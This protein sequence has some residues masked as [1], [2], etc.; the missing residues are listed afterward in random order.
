MHAKKR[1]TTQCVE[2]LRFEAVLHRFCHV[3][4]F[5]NYSV[6][7]DHNQEK[8]HPSAFVVLPLQMS[9]IVLHQMVSTIVVVS[10]RQ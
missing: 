4:E 8:H 10:I 6:Y 1:D 3:N 9:I 7:F 2:I 5:H